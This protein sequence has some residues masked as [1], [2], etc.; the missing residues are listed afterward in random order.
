MV[1]YTFRG[2]DFDTPVGTMPRARTGY[3][4][5]SIYLH[6]CPFITHTGYRPI[7]VDNYLKWRRASLPWI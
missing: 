3:C 2:W 1:Y 7:A 4:L 6:G 5:N